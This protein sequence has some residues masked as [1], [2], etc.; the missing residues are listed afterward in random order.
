MVTLSLRATDWPRAFHASSGYLVPKPVQRWVTAVSFG[1]SKWAH[2]SPTAADGSARVIL[3]I[4]LGRDGHDLT[5]RDDDALL[6]AAVDEV[7]EHLG[8]QLQPDAHRLSRWPASF[9]QY[10][11]GHTARVDAIE[12]ALRRDAPGVFIAGASYRGIGIPACVQQAGAAATAVAAFMRD[13]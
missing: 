3:R 13:R 11:P 6:G 8:L 12:A 7:G 10:R 4:S 5:D 2:W 1:S 9:P